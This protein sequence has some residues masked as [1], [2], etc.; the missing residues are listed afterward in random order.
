MILK[1]GR[2][3]AAFGMMVLALCASPVFASNDAI[4][5]LLKVLRDNGT[6]SE[7][8]YSVL[9]NSVDADAERTH[10]EM[11]KTTDQ[12]LAKIV[13][14]DGKKQWAEKIKLK[15]DLRLRRQYEKV[16]DADNADDPSRTR[17][18]YRLRLGAVGEVNDDVKVG[19]GF[20][21]GSDDPTSTNETLDDTF[22][23]KDVRLD[24][25]YAQW[26]PVDYA[27]VVAGKFKR[28]AYLWAPTDLIW[29]GDINPEG[30]SVHLH[31]DNAAGTSYANA[32]V[33]ILD[34]ES[35]SKD[36]P[37]MKY[38][39]LGHKFKIDNIYANVAGALYRFD[40]VE[41]EPLL[42]N[43]RDTNTV[44]A[45][46]NYQYDYDSLG[47]S[48]EL[49]MQDVFMSG[50]VFAVFGDYIKN[51]DS[52]E[53]KGYALGFK[54][55][56]K[57]VSNRHQWQFKYVYAD[58]E[59]DAFL[60]NFPDSDRFGGE[61]AIKGSEFI[62]NYGLHKNVVFGIDYYDTERDAPDAAPFASNDD[63]QQKVLQTDVVFKF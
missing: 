46:G 43:I 23:T 57:K 4:K 42:D 11:E 34:K 33:W 19:L 39:Q 40:D 36:D 9:K 47:L 24:Y 55:G 51:S 35:G 29:D 25:A 17:Y 10:A 21:S 6:I 62:F 41:G 22:S 60:D 53:D 50:K 13:Q 8:A 16:D 26:Q 38:I 54:F 31:T 32:G 14:A 37:F 1:Y 28:K 44:N 48:A 18:R 15:G 59:Q 30:L 12:K 7:Q 63:D 3:V 58:L 27:R 52:E 61:T 20:A 45:D 2:A 49:G 56:D 5:E